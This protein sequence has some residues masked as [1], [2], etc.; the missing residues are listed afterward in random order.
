M[1]KMTLHIERI[2]DG[3]V[4]IDVVDAD[5]QADKESLIF[6]VTVAQDYTKTAQKAA[7]K[8]VLNYLNQFIDLSQGGRY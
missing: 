5:D 1:I 6:S 8:A 2:E 4:K 3:V 7:L